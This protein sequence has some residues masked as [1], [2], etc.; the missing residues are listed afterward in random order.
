MEEEIAELP[1]D[2]HIN[3]LVDWLVSRKHSS[4]D[5]AA[6]LKGIRQGINDAIQDMPEH[7]GI[8]KLL[9]GT[10][11]NYFHCLQIVEI[12]KVTEADS[13]NMLGW[14][15][16][17]RMKDW[18]GVVKTYEKNG[19]GIAESGQLL[20]RYVVHEIP[21]IKLTMSQCSQVHQDCDKKEED[22]AK[23]SANAKN[24]YLRKVKEIGIEGVDVR[25]ELLTLVQ[26]LPETLDR[27]SQDFS[28]LKGLIEYYDEYVHYTTS[29][30][31]EQLLPMLKFLI[32]NGNV[33]TF[34][35]KRGRTPSSVEDPF[36]E[37]K[38]KISKQEDDGGIDFGDDDEGIDFGDDNGGIDFGDDAGIDFGGEDEINYGDDIIDFDTV[39][40]DSKIVCE[41]TED[42]VARGKEARSLLHNCDTRDNILDNLY[43]LEAF[44][45]QALDNTSKGDADAVDLFSEAPK[46]VQLVSAD[47]ITGHLATLA[48]L[49]EKLVSP[50]MTQLFLISDSLTYVEQL[51]DTLKRLER[52][53][54]PQTNVLATLNDRRLESG[55]TERQ[56]SKRL[57]QLQDATRQ[58]KKQL[59]Q[60]ISSKYKGRQVTLMGVTSR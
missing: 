59:E 38:Q 25:S 53:S 47:A 6:G 31:K 42:S 4:K 14:Y 26:D 18:Q 45:L 41:D 1:I 12:L 54:A 43:E 55:K 34:Q 40:T 24:I 22:L 15:S 52:R 10:Y 30:P 39:A 3:K 9:S 60:A 16:S 21:A 2:I 27:I 11:I 13:K 23:A 8:T 49:L 36:E 50:G 32:E 20:H 19:A 37:F 57:A 48:T 44:L 35:Y 33:T 5:W 29:N 58:L 17:Q 28:G 7:G 56:L 51:A 46:S